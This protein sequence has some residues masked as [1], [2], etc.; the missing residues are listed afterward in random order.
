MREYSHLLTK[1][2]ECFKL[3]DMLDILI[4]DSLEFAYTENKNTD[5]ENYNFFFDV[6]C[7]FF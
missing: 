3:S 6:L 2:M 4:F 5:G 7:P 1:S